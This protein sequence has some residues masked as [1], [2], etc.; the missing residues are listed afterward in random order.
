MMNECGKEYMV[1]QGKSHCNELEDTVSSVTSSWH[2]STDLHRE[3]GS[4]T[5][6]RNPGCTLQSHREVLKQ[7]T[8]SGPHVQ[9]ILINCS[10]DKI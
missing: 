3:Q 4:T 1:K 6:V 2:E 7:T 10:G 8:M 9:E 5:V